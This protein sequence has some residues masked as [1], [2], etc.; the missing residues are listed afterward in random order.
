LAQ[1]EAS[2]K[3]GTSGVVFRTG[4]P[5]SEIKVIFWD[6][7]G[8]ILTNGWDQGQRSHVLAD[9]GVN[10]EDYESRHDAA[11]FFWERGLSTAE[12]FFRKTV[13]AA[14]Q[15]SRSFS[16]DDLWARVCG[17]SRI[18]HPGSL[19]ILKYLRL[20]NLYTLATLNNESRELNQYRLDAFQLRPYFDFFVCSGYVREMKPHKDIYRAAIE[21]SGVPGNQTLLIDDKEENCVSATALGMHAI[22]FESPFQLSSALKEFGIAVP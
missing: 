11:N 1:V 7:G 10:L 6:I 14:D 16:Y 18:L 4:D 2:G 12:D 17:E 5:V 8:V 21:I 22:R 3:H 19:E 15:P 9:L 13:F 20:G